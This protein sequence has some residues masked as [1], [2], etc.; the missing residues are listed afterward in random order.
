MF[1]I[2]E[3]S[4][5]Y[6][7]GY[8]QFDLVRDKYSTMLS[9]GYKAKGFIDKK[10]HEI[11]E[12]VPCWLMEEFICANR[13]NANIVIIFLL[14]NALQHEEIARIFVAEGYKKILFIP[15][16]M[17]SEERRKMY[18]IYNTF[19]EGEYSKL[20]NIPDG[21]EILKERHTCRE[22]ARTGE[23]WLTYF[24]PS[25]LLFS[26]DGGQLYGDE[27][28]RFCLPYRELYEYLSGKCETCSCYMEFMGKQDNAEFLI[29][30]RKLFLSFE[31]ERNLGM[32]YFVETAAFVNWND[33]GYF[34][35]I[36]GHHR[37]AYL[38]YKGYDQ[39]PVRMKK[40]DFL[41]WKN[42][43]EAVKLSSVCNLPCPIPLPGFADRECNFEPRW[44]RVTD[45]FFL[46]LSEQ[47]KGEMCFVEAD[48]NCGFYARN[49]QRDKRFK[50]FIVMRGK[51]HIRLCQKLNRVLRQEIEICETPEILG[52][53]IQAAYVDMDI[54]KEEWMD[55]LL[56]APELLCLVFEVTQKNEKQY[57]EKIQKAFGSS[58]EYICHYV[59]KEM[60]KIYGIT[61]GEIE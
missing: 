3:T 17:G 21:D 58:A 49:F 16:D 12:A 40:K 18:G 24:V 14:Q 37:A 11:R 6:F 27:N 25:E 9:E 36:D 29:D 5:I 30:R 10:A 44:K 56:S 60:K 15:A 51:Q 52:T 48:M 59:N 43:E 54:W 47:K 39:I 35:I 61:K 23:K 31:R 55:K 20:C 42:E 2:E 32:G 1:D 45:F 41:K 13:E 4:E 57:L 38:A 50:C 33:R 26:Y 8:S 7:Y 22:L 46:K 34:N 19:L 28:I 53:K